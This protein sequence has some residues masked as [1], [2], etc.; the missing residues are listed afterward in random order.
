MG[1]DGTQTIW[2]L[3]HIQICLRVLL[4][5]SGQSSGCWRCCDVLNIWDVVMK[6]ASPV[7]GACSACAICLFLCFSISQQIFFVDVLVELAIQRSELL[8]SR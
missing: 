3:W 8:V 2:C 6:A 5:A 1:W 4:L 7:K